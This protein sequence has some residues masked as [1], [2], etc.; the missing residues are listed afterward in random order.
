MYKL[1]GCRKRSRLMIVAFA[2]GFAIM[3][4]G[5]IQK[6][7]N[8]GIADTPVVN[9][10]GNTVT[11]LVAESEGITYQ[12]NGGFRKTNYSTSYWLKQYET[13]SG[14]F[15]QKKKIVGAE[16]TNPAIDCY[17]IYN[18]TIWLYAN[19]LKAFD[20]KNLEEINNEKKIAAANGMKKTIFPYDNRLINAAV[21]NGY[22]DFIADNGE[23]Y[24]LSLT[25]YTITNKA[26]IE[27]HVKDPTKSIR[28]LL[29]EDDY[30]T[31]CD[32][33][34]NKAYIL[35]KD[36]TAAVNTSL[37]DYSLQ[38]VA[39][40]MRLFTT[41]YTVRKLGTHNSFS[42]QNI[43]QLSVNTF[44]N[45]C[46]AKDTYNDAVIHL[47]NPDGYLLIH[48][49]VL[50]EKSKAIITRIDSHGKK[51]W[52]TNTGVSTKI[53]HCMLSG[54]YC[55]ITTNTDYMFSPHIGKDALCIIDTETGKISK[56]AIKE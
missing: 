22:I 33:L 48:Q 15:L 17:G 25:N 38:E 24:R 23:A 50:G 3:M 51:I 16:V 52:E 11:I 6:H 54:K 14:K 19:G 34:L 18:N 49:D 29:N 56:S 41:N 20:C 13:G 47:S 37:T 46:F 55:I 5:C 36:S 2:T 27:D 42:Y 44:L 4:N 1:Q 31:R 45:P 28:S 7:T 35:A 43:H 10:M 39:Y 40:R 8:Y 12:E 32:T 26:E 30:G 53:A 21:E 9:A